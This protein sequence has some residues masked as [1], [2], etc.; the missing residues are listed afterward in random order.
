MLGNHVAAHVAAQERRPIPDPNTLGQVLRRLNR[1]REAIGVYWQAVEPIYRGSAGR[2][3]DYQTDLSELFQLL[4]G[5]F[6]LVAANLVDCLKQKR[7]FGISEH[8]NTSSPFDLS[9]SP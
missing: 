4:R 8:V 1:I 5:D 7:P 3:A 6:T 9:F 2:W